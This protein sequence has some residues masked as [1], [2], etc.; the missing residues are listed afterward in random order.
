ME[1]LKFRYFNHHTYMKHA[2]RR[3][4]DKEGLMPEYYSKGSTDSITVPG[5]A[6]TIKELM[7]RYEKGRPIPAE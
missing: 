7:N 1:G 2:T 6:I 3:N 4:G 5:M